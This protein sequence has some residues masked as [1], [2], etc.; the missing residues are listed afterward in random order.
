[1]NYSVTFLGEVAELRCFKTFTFKNG[2]AAL[3][4]VIDAPWRPRMRSL[5]ILDEGSEFSPTRDGIRKL[6]DLMDTI[7]SS[8]EVK[9]AVVIAE[10]VHFG[11]GRAIED[12]VDPSGE[13]VR[14]FLR[15][16]A[17]RE[18]LS[19]AASPAV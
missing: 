7:L 16:E 17:A 10:V 9:I 11:I 5:L 18:W 3:T 13:R 19:A 6:K 14:V 15:E 12:R 2:L 4:E 8:D 1:M